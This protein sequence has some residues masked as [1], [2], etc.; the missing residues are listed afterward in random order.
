MSKKI[1]PSERIGELTSE[2]Y[3]KKANS[4]IT[5][6]QAQ[7]EAIIKYLDEEHEA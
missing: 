3:G 2:I 6:Y 4:G 5:P 1:K 7:G